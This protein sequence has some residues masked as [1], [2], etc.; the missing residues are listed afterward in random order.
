MNGPGQPARRVLLCGERAFAARG[1]GEALRKDGCSVT[2]F[3]RGEP[4]RIGETVHEAVDQ[5]HLNAY[6]DSTYDTV[7]NFIVLKDRDLQENLA[8]LGSLLNMCEDH[9]V[10]HL[11]HISSMSVYP[12][13]AGLITERTAV[14]DDPTEPPFTY[15]DL[16][17]A[18]DAY[19]RQHVPAEIKL[20]LLRPAY[21]LGEGMDD[22][23]GSIGRVISAERLLVL[24]HPYR[25]RPLISRSVLHAALRRLVQ[26]PPQETQEVL[27][28][29]DPASPSCLDYLQKCCESL[30]V[31]RRAVSLPLHLWVPYYLAHER[32]RKGAGFSYGR[33]LRGIF[34][35]SQLQHYDPGWTEE[36]LGL[37]LRSNWQADL[38]H[39]RQV[40]TAKTGGKS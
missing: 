27:L 11:V 40:G 25:Q 17:T 30:G 24:G 35:R 20:S 18:T 38:L 8:Y 34:A 28:M 21:I 10:K 3:S 31:A 13:G 36:R 9:S 32:E 6:L 37:S 4:G 5:I 16:K 33:F 12:D 15:A 26:Q 19:L 22:P 29:V 7:V 39:Q 2:G 23:I 14:R 1:L